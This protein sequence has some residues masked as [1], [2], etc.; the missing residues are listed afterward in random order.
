MSCL[1]IAL[2]Q[3]TVLEISTIRHFIPPR[4]VFMSTAYVW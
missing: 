4:V 1:S 2:S 3:F